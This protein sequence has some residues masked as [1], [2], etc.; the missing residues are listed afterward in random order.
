MAAVKSE[1]PEKPRIISTS[2]VWRVLQACDRCRMK[3]VPCDGGTPCAKCS[4]NRL[5]C[6]TSDKL[7]RQAFPKGYTVNLERRVKELEQENLQL[8]TQMSLGLPQ[9]RL[10]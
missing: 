8:R 2:K 7:S 1:L 5:E 10:G 3:K 6:T 4:T 9:S